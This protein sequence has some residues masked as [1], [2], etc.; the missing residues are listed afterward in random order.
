METRTDVFLTLQ[1]INHAESDCLFGEILCIRLLIQAWIHCQLIPT[2]KVLFALAND[3]YGRFQE[4]VQEANQRS[5]MPARNVALPCKN[6]QLAV[7]VHN[8]QF[9]T[10]YQAYFKRINFEKAFKFNLL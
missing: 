5:Q 7:P 10:Q 2:I 6:A 3:I 1:F 9:I 4:T 8:T